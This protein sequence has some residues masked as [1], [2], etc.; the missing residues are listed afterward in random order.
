METK[1]VSELAASL[2][3]KARISN[4]QDKAILQETI[5]KLW[6]SQQ[7]IDKLQSELKKEKEDRAK[8]KTD[9]ETTLKQDRIDYRKRQIVDSSETIYDQLDPEVKFVTVSKLVDKALNEKNLQFTFDDKGD[10][11]LLSKDGTKYYG[12]NNTVV[13]PKAFVNDVLGQNK[14]AKAAEKKEGDD[15]N[16]SQQRQ[17]FIPDNEQTTFVEDNLSVA[18]INKKNREAYQSSNK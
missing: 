2:A 7:H 5:N 10:M 6:S 9:F 4:E 1:N 11:Q 16:N 12:A 8:D 17:T 3:E 13:T 15:I 14:I 18:S